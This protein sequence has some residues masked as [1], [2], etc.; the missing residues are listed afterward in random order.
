MKSWSAGGKNFGCK[1]ER[2]FGSE[3]NLQSKLVGEFQMEIGHLRG[4]LGLNFRCKLERY[5]GSD[6]NL[7]PKLVH[8]VKSNFIWK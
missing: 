5:P 3:F 1:L 7:H 6:F 4:H 2:V 8:R